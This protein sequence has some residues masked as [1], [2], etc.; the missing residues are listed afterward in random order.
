MIYQPRLWVVVTPDG[1]HEVVAVT[2]AE[3]IE[4]VAARLGRSVRLIPTFIGEPGQTWRVCVAEPSARVAAPT[5]YL[6]D[7]A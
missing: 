1:R 6:E 3:A 2:V 7:A 5:V 4:L